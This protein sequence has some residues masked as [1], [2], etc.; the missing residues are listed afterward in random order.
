ML[1][2]KFIIGLLS[3]YYSELRSV[4][5]GSR[6][7]GQETV[8]FFWEK[9]KQK[10]KKKSRPY[11][12]RKWKKKKNYKE[13]SF[14]LKGTGAKDRRYSNQQLIRRMYRNS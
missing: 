9:K 5:P 3:F 4:Q 14:S 8:E 1:I 10:E 2:R 12:N 11:D 13:K 7:S 6:V